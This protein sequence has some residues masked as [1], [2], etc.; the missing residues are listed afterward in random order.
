MILDQYPAEVVFFKVLRKPRENLLL[1]IADRIADIDGQ[2][3][4]FRLHLRHTDIERQIAGD[5]IREANAQIPSAEVKT[6]AAVIKCDPVVVL[7]IGEV[8]TS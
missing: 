6:K 1:R 8:Q 4:D 2:L 5:L 7:L 3:T